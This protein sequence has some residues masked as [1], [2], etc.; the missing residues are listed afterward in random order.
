MPLI[1]AVFDCAACYKFTYVCKHVYVLYFVLVVFS[2]FVCFC[3]LRD[4]VR[5]TYTYQMFSFLCKI[6][7]VKS[8]TVELVFH[9]FM[10]M[11]ICGMENQST[12]G[13]TRYRPHGQVY[14]YV[15]YCVIIG[16]VY[17]ISG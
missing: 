1:Q 17:C 7:V 12:T 16:L 15:L 2:V 8:A 5:F 6:V 13:W 10:S 14:R 3:C 11:S 4:E 9:R